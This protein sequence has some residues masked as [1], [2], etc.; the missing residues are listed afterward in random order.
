MENAI[1]IPNRKRLGGEATLAYLLLAPAVLL[2]LIFMAYPIFYVFVVSLFKT[3]KLAHIQEFDGFR[4]YGKLL[5][6]KD[7]W[8]IIGRYLISDD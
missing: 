8:I 5:S 1:G 2:M 6:D 7:T 3:N 4:I